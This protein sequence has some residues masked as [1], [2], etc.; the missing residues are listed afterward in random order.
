MIKYIWLSLGLMVATVASAA[1]DQVFAIA[2]AGDVD[3]ALV[4]HVRSRLEQTSGAKVRLAAPVPLEAGQAMDVIG[5]AAVKTMKPGDYGIIVLARPLED[6]PQG[7]CLPEEHFGVLNVAKL[8][9]DADTDHVER[10][11]TQNGLR[12][13]SM[14]VGMSPCP[15]PLC[16]LTGYDKAEDLDHMSGNFCPPCQDRFERL[17]RKAG[18]RMIAPPAS[19]LETEPAAEPASTEVPAVAPV[20]TESAPAPAE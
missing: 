7:V 15:F 20:V 14:L 16:V 5:R 6:Q 13:E 10:R 11:L 2:S 8:E 19:V 1:E 9:V 4:E 17:A 12:V 18:L 3:A